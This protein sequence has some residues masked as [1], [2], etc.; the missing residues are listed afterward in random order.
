MASE[1]SHDGCSSEQD[2]GANEVIGGGTDP[3]RSHP[4]KSDSADDLPVLAV[5][6]L[7]VSKRPAAARVSDPQQQSGIQQN[8]NGALQYCA[9]ACVVAPI[10]G[11][12]IFKWWTYQAGG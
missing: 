5:E 4:S 7:H 2:N 12:I 6:R 3:L 9:G 1:F 8:D 11:Q 10:A